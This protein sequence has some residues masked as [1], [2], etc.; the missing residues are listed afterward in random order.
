MN[1]FL[2]LQGEDAIWEIELDKHFHIIYLQ[3]CI[4]SCEVGFRLWNCGIFA[5]TCTW[6]WWTIE[7][8]GVSQ[9]ENNIGKPWLGTDT[10]IDKNEN[11]TL[12]LYI[13][14]D[15]MFSLRIFCR[16]VY[17]LHYF[18]LLFEHEISRLW[19]SL[20]LG[21]TDDWF[22]CSHKDCAIITQSSLYTT[23]RRLL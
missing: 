7:T 2:P 5:G 6:V 20:E 1:F 11:L 8:V 18:C 10:E 3:C 22:L 12:P 16:L 19:Q 13:P 14:V 15:M 21:E 17:C 9:E 23:L 4:A